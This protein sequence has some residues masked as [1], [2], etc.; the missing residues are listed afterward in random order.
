MSRESEYSDNDINQIILKHGYER[1][2]GYHKNSSSTHILLHECGMINQKTSQSLLSKP[3]CSFIPCHPRG[4]LSLLYVQG[5]AKEHGIQCVTH[6]TKKDIPLNELI[7]DSKVPLTWKCNDE[8]MTQSWYQVR[9]RALSAKQGKFFI[10]D[11]DKRKSPSKH[12]TIDQINEICLSAELDFDGV[13]PKTR[14]IRKVYTHVDCGT[15]VPLAFKQL[16]KW[17]PSMCTTCFPL[18]QSRLKAFCDYLAEYEMTL[19]NKVTL[20]PNSSQVD[21][22][23]QI[24]INCLKCNST[25]SSRTF[26]AVRYRGFTYCDNSSCINTY[27]ENDQK[28]QSLEFYLN[29]IKSGK[30]SSFVQFQQRYPKAFVYIKRVGYKNSEGIKKVGELYKIIRRECNWKNNHLPIEYTREELKESFKLAISNGAKNIGELISAI[31][32][33]VRNYITR[34]KGNGNYTHYEILEDLNFQFKRNHYLESLDDILLFIKLRNIESWSEMTCKF[35]T[36]TTQIKDLA[37]KDK[38]FDAL[39]WE[40]LKD[41]SSLSDDQ[42]LARAEKLWGENTLRSLEEL[43]K[44]EFGLIKNIRER[45]LTEQ[46]RD[47]LGLPVLNNWVEFTLN[48]T[49]EYIEKFKYVSATDWHQQNSGLY[50][51][52][53][54]SNW[55]SK[56]AKACG[57][58]EY[59]GM[60]G[61]RYDS[62]TETAIANLLYIHEISYI[63]HPPIHSFKGKKGGKLFADFFLEEK[64]IWI[65]VWA[66]KGVMDIG[67]SWLKDYPIQRKYKEKC[68]TNNDI[69]LCSIEGMLLYRSVEISNKKIKRGLTSFL[70]NACLN[71]NNSG[72]QISL[73]AQIIRTIRDS[74]VKMSQSPCLNL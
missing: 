52:A 32:Y 22:S 34:L 31:P 3:S 43:S 27:D 28:D 23:Q 42:L 63:N 41:F 49:I 46:L 10:A 51:Q 61:Y 67:S 54:K 1:L 69:T 26:D 58:G 11:K 66:F 60:D 47:I 62:I 73:D 53:A 40:P 29:L 19:E 13:V 38:V 45:R 56:I 37:L 30:I 5:I 12:L 57:W 17:T 50:K 36:V 59:I 24:A 39:E 64:K 7:I 9:T 21:R 55:L 68:Y 8:V 25:S 44:I 48:E 33:P 70:E 16:E 71:L 4:K 20:L 74:L 18:E 65:E 72:I 35:P 15:E 6:P 14:I 2:E